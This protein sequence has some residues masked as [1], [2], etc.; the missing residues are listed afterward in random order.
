MNCDI[1]GLGSAD[2]KTLF[3]VNVFGK[4]GIWRCY[5][6]LTAKQSGAIDPEICRL[7]WA[8]DPTLR[9]RP[10]LSCQSSCSNEKHEHLYLH[11]LPA[12]SSPEV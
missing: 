12:G 2:G 6:H 11:R 7:V 4:K 8:I 9:R 10:D 3:R 5:E 1:C